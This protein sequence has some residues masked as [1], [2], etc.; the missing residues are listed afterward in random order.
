MDLLLCSQLHPF[1]E[2]QGEGQMTV[3]EQ[4]EAFI[5]VQHLKTTVCNLQLSRDGAKDPPLLRLSPY[6]RSQ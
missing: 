2:Q 6:Q 4:Q 1:A 5:T 3:Q